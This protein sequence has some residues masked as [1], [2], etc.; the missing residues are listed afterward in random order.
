MDGRVVH[1]DGHLGV[2]VSEHG[3]VVDVGRA[4]D[5]LPGVRSLKGLVVES[6]FH[7][8]REKGGLLLLLS[9]RR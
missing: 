4:D 7:A 3:A 1:D 5:G 9:L 6:R 2:S 8:T